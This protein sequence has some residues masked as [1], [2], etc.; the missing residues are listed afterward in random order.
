MRA[1]HR[2]PSVSDEWRRASW[3]ACLI[4]LH[5]LREAEGGVSSSLEEHGQLPGTMSSASQTGLP[6]RLWGLNW[7]RYACTCPVID[8]WHALR[9]AE[10]ELYEDSEIAALLD[11]PMRSVLYRF[12]DSVLHFTEV[13]DERVMAMLEMRDQFIP[14]A[15]ELQDRFFALEA[16]TRDRSRPAV[17]R[18][19]A[20]DG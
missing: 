16:R 3:L 1:Q 4:R 11:S 12:R 8:G 14:W 18:G 6:Q 2:K 5:A 9:R 13:R 7:L 17:Q 20:A 19:V 15:E 10:P